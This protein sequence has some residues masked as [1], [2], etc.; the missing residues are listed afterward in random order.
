MENVWHIMA[1]SCCGDFFFPAGS[2]SLGRVDGMM[3]RAK[4]RNPDY[5]PDYIAKDNKMQ[6][7]QQRFIL[8]QDNATKHTNNSLCK[9]GRSM[10]Q[11][12]T[13]ED[14]SV[15]HSCQVHLLKF[16]IAYTHVQLVG[17]WCALLTAGK[18]ETTLCALC[19][20]TEHFM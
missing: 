7:N 16:S 6:N 15:H 11:L 14:M 4:Q 20:T 5:R 19:R 10:A 8:Q 17:N 1:A 13:F 12:Q 18:S 2:W 3:T 9:N